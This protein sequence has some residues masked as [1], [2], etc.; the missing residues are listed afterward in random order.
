[1][2]TQTLAFNRASKPISVQEFRDAVL[3]VCRPRFPTAYYARPQRVALAISGGVDSMAM[4]YLFSRLVR[5]YRGIK[6]ADYPT[7]TAFGVVVDHKLREESTQEASRVAQELKRLGLK[8]LIKTLNWRELKWHGIE[9]TTMPNL[10][11]VA[12]TMRYQALGAACTYLQ[13]QSLFFAHHQDDQYETVLMR[14]L[15]GHGYRGLQGIREA[16][17]IPECYELHGVYKSGLLDDQMQKRPFLSFKPAGREMRRLRNILRD[18]KEAEPWD[19]IKSYLSSNDR[20]MSFPGHLSRE[21]DPKVPY[22]TPLQSEDGGVTIYRP[23]LEFDK[24]R[25]IATCEANGVQWFEDSTNTDPTLTTRNAI[26]QLT[27]KHTLPKALQKPSIL[28]LAQRS[29]RRVRLEEAEAHRLLARASTIK[30][31]DPN[32]GT[33]RIDVSTL[34]RASPQQMRRPFFQAREEARR[35]SRRLLAAIA[36]RK[37][38]AFVTPELH[39]PPLTN[40]ENAVGRLFPEL[41]GETDVAPAAQPKAFSIAGVLFEPVPNLNSTSWLLSRAPYSSRQPLPERKLPGYL[42]YRAGIFKMDGEGDQP[43]RHRHWRGWKTAKLWDGRFWIR[44][45]AC[46]AAKFQVFPFLPSSA[47]PF[48]MAL[49]PRERANLEKILKHYAPGKVR[50]TLPG[51][52][53]VEEAALD[54]QDAEPILT[55][56]ALPTLGIH[57][58][59]LERWVRYEA[60]YKNIDVTLLAS[61]K[62]KSS[63]MS[64][65]GHAHPPV[66]KQSIMQAK[67]LRTSQTRQAPGTWK[68]PACQ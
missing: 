11:S 43:S 3:S 4:A 59:G 19:Q 46:V 48:R 35:R 38:I 50:Y 8:A 29:K 31:F 54:R 20:S 67:R 24:A 39:L 23:L 63:K 55:L 45:S 14:L 10:E 65:L 25:L 6:I 66:R 12:R 22:L 61:G 68:A 26:R 47:K 13:S 56:L 40:L 49:P 34:W 5:M 7:D 36:L 18:D 60:R 53:S 37:L 2:S 32:A 44:V 28:A 15:A 58:P 51:L 64:L 41:S 21:F 16:N 30:D 42:N 52:Y 33:L 57:I 27:R 62:K 9:P 1:M 17:A